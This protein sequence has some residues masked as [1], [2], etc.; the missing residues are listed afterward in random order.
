M[1][2]TKTIALVTFPLWACLALSAQNVKIVR[3]REIDDVLVNPGIGFTTF[4][5]FNG[6]ALNEGQQ[7]TEGYPIAYQPFKGTLKNI[8]YPDTSLAYFRI[9]WRFLEPQ[10]GNYRWDLIDSALRTARE[11][12][13]TLMLRIVPYGMEADDD[14]PD[15]YHSL[16]GDKTARL[17]NPKWR[18]NPEDPHYVEHVGQLIREAGLRYDGVPDLQS[19]DVAIVGAWGEG[20]G[21]QLLSSKTRQALL[22]AYLNSFQKTPLVMML[23]D[24]QTNGYGLSKRDVGWRVDCFGDMGAPNANWS[25][26]L[27]YYPQAIISFGMENAWKKAPVAL[28][29][30]FVM[31]HWKDS[32]WNLDYIIDQSL[33]WHISSFNAKSSPIPPAWQPQVNRWLKK[34]GYRFVLRKFTYPDLVQSGGKL[35]FTSWWENKGVAPCYQRFALAL[36]LKSRTNNQVLLTDADI[37]NWLPGDNLYANS[38]F[39]PTALPAGK[40]ELSLAIIDPGSKN[41]KIKLAIAGAAPDGWYPMGTV[42][43]APP[44]RATRLSFLFLAMGIFWGIAKVSYFTFAR[45]H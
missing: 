44:R 14:A 23:S 38:L 42:N 8:G 33:K 41:P 13:Q 10:P 45:I 27:D 24:P 31:Q 18:T 37:R 29:S 3:P 22:D 34:M 43:I 20:D 2:H 5:R 16:V 25:H 11:R 4:Q 12:G 1:R 15:W 21:S 36:R 39:I 19:V 30:C 6:D 28:E 26:M 40:Y 7:W 17:S 35:D 32:G 9:C